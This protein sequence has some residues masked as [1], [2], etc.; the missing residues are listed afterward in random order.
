MAGLLTLH[1]TQHYCRCCCE[2]AAIHQVVF[3]LPNA[4]PAAD[5]VPPCPILFAAAQYRSS[6]TNSGEPG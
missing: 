2:E 1:N 5:R 6:V 3:S 4:L